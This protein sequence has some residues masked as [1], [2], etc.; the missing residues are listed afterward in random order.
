MSEASWLPGTRRVRRQWSLAVTICAIVG[1]GVGA[2]LHQLFPAVVSG[3]FLLATGGVLVVELIVF[4]WL[5]EQVADARDPQRLSVATAITIGRAGV[6]AAFA[7][8]LA[9]GRPSGAL[10]WF[11]GTLFATA[12]LLDGVDGAVARATN[13]VSELGD[14]LDR[15]VDALIVLVGAVFAVA[16]GVAPVGY[17][18]V[19]F[20]RYGFLLGIL[21]RQRRG[22]PV[23]PLPPS[24]VRRAIGTT[25]FVAIWL[26]LL[27]VPGRDL[28]RTLTMVAAIPFLL[29][30]ARDWL[31]ITGRR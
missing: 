27:P 10:V 6:L 1:V 9:S 22:R 30:F 8:F 12:A 23:E 14:R 7:G 19:G 16:E 20:G 18:V 2:V 3:G 4:G 11:P 31:A 5:F 21:W 17:L 15:E 24:L 28:S 29:S 26:A 13:C 25:Q